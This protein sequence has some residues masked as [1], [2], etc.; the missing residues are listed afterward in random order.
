[1]SEL[2]KLLQTQSVAAN[3][4]NPANPQE[5]ISKISNFSK[6]GYPKVAFGS[7]ECVQSV[8]KRSKELRES[9]DQL[10]REA[11]DDWA[12][13]S[14]D[15]AKLIAFAD[16]L[17]T[18]RI[19]ESGGIPDTYTAITECEHCGTVPIWEGCLPQVDGC[20]WCLNRHMGL[21]MPNTANQ[22]Q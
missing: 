5:E 2:S 22:E 21:P 11:G 7:R 15:P 10:Q 16:L 8:D 4:A 14:G 17:A 9:P 13:V 6:R 12:E 1:M 19:R 18:S 3:P 20:P